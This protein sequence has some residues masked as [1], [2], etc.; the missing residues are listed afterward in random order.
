MLFWA[1]PTAALSGTAAAVG[2]A[3]INSVGNLAGYVSPYAVGAIRDATGSMP[4]ALM[5]LAVAMLISAILTLFTT[6][7]KA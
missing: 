4:L 7:K 6:R 5:T 1:M 3:W 2:I